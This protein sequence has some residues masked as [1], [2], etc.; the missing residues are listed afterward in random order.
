MTPQRKRGG[1]EHDPPTHRSSHDEPSY[2]ERLAVLETRQEQFATKLDVE[3]TKLWFWGSVA[4]AVV[5]VLSLI[6]TGVLI[7]LR[8]MD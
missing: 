3:K 7:W 6:G 2:A 1:R 8:A 5:A 4:S